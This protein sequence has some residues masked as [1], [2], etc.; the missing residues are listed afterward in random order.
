MDAEDRFF[1]AGTHPHNPSFLAWSTQFMIRP[2]GIQPGS[3][4]PRKTYFDPHLTD[5]AFHQKR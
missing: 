3:G 5:W 2:V 4:T 1:G